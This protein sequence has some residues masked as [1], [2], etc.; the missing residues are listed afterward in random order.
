MCLYQPFMQ[1]WV[2]TENMFGMEM[3]VLFALYFFVHKWCDML[4]VY[5]EAC[6]I[7]WETKFVPFIAAIVNL[8]VNIILVKTIG[9]P[10]ILIST[11]VS[12]VFI[13]DTGY[14]K[15]LFKTY[16]ESVDEG[17]K[18]YWSR[19][20]RYILIASIACAITVAVCSLSTIESAWL[21]LIVNGIICVLIPNTVFVLAWKGLPEFAYAKNML[22][23]FSR[24]LMRK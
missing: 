17:L 21:R 6:G 1:I 14:A 20:I 10:G 13:Y 2:G 12:V 11:I 16:F 19:Q 8:T 7:W 23:K 18:Q 5:Q 15:V 4:Y 9:L 3:V 22:D 24:K